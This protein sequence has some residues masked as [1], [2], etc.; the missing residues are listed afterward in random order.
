MSIDPLHRATREG[1]AAVA[2]SPVVEQM[3]Q[4]GPPHVLFTAWLRLMAVV[5]GELERALDHVEAAEARNAWR[6]RVLPQLRADLVARDEV[7]APATLAIEPMITLVEDVRGW[8]HERPLRLVGALYASGSMLDD[9]WARVMD[10]ARRPPA[11]WGSLALASGAL[12][13]VVAG[14]LA[15]VAHVQAILSAL[16]AGTPGQSL[17]QALNADAGAH[18]VTHDPREVMAAVD[19]GIETWAHHPY[20]AARYGTRGRRFTR[21]DSAWL[22]TL[23]DLPERVRRERLDWL[24]RLLA[25]RGMPT[26]LLEDHLRHLHQALSAAVP[27]RA[28]RYAA[29]EASSRVLEAGRRAVLPEF[30]AIA[31]SVPRDPALGSLG[32]IVVSAVADE[33]LGIPGVVACVEAW[34]AERLDPAC[35]AAVRQAIARA[36]AS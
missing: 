12:E 36:R 15:L 5:I 20:Y 10:R 35:L 24:G 13:P 1:L 34:L 30:D 6:E 18:E 7:P 14:A 8:A 31:A 25:T 33:R 11:S 28:A 2:G 16:A 3:A 9:A 27:E 26:L 17:A 29:L 23:V 32:P 19:A 4:E 22:V 21:S